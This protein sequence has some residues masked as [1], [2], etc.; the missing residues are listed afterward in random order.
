MK[1]GLGRKAT[2]MFTH[3]HADQRASARSSVRSSRAPLVIG[4]VNNMPDQALR[5]TERQF[6][7]LLSAASHDFVVRLK[8]FSLPEIQRSETALAHIGRYYDDIAELED[9]PPDGL[10]VTGTAPRAASLKEEAYWPALSRLVEWT[11]DNAISS[12]WSCLAAHAAVLH[13]DGVDRHA[14]GPKLSGVFE[15]EM[16]SQAHELVHG[17]P[18]KW[19]VPHS[20]F[21]GLAEE[22]LA[23]RG[24]DILSWSPDVGADIFVKQAEC[25][26]VFFQGHPEYGAVALLGE[27]RRDVGRFL[28]G[29]Q[30]WY[31]DLPRSYF[32]ARVE[33][34]LRKLQERALA[35]RDPELLKELTALTTGSTLQDPWL[36]TAARI[37]ANWLSLL[38]ERRARSLAPPQYSLLEAEM[39]RPVA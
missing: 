28:S 31:P 3:R 30:E 39:S 20:R 29:E 38:S 13:L 22:A 2:Q 4:L 18:A 26:S 34:E 12:V 24:Y 8:L 27:Y 10:I 17:T 36:S 6:C 9:D 23:V 25:V 37:Y 35:D 1:I 7:T 21:N 11:Q 15:C 32:D 19:R 33:V 16:S 14:L 5:A